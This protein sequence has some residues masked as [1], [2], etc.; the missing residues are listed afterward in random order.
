MT[1]QSDRDEDRADREHDE[2]RDRKDEVERLWREVEAAA[3]VLVQYA[4]PQARMPI[5]EIERRRSVLRV[6]CRRAVRAEE[7]TP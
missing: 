1:T 4:S 3:H 2:A 7:M 5:P 6:A